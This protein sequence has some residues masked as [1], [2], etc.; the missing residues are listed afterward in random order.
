M[1]SLPQSL[2]IV[3]VYESKLWQNRQN[4]AV[5][6][7]KK[8]KHLWRLDVPTSVSNNFHFYDIPI[9][10]DSNYLSSYIIC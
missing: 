9:S 10:S 6:T 1:N 8:V 2:H 3:N 7:F 5:K 4:K